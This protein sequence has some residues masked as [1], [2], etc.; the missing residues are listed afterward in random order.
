MISKLIL[1]LRLTITGCFRNSVR[2]FLTITGMCIGMIC[3]ILGN[4]AMS[5][6]V[7][8]AYRKAMSFPEQSF[9]VSGDKEDLNWYADKLS[10]DFKLDRA[11]YRMSDLFTLK[12]RYNYCGKEIYNICVLTGMNTRIENC[13]VPTLESDSAGYGGYFV[14]STT[15]IKGRDF[16]EN[17]IISGNNV[18]I[19]EKSTENAIF[20]NE[21]AIGKTIRLY[22][23]SNSIELTIIGVVNDYFT[24]RER[25]FNFNRNLSSKDSDSISIESSIYVP[26][27]LFDNSTVFDESELKEFLVGKINSEDISRVNNAI[28]SINYDSS[29]SYRPVNCITRG[30]LINEVNKIQ[31]EFNIVKIVFSIFL[32]IISG[33]II[34]TVLLFSIKERIYEIGIRRAVGASS[35]SILTQFITEGTIYSLISLTFATAIST[36]LSNFITYFLRDVSFIDFTM[37][38]PPRIILAAVGISLFE[39]IVFSFIPAFIASHVSPTEAIRWD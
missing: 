22:S 24:T 18:C 20:R 4:S 7:A 9:L 31:E 23:L 12:S 16:T 11:D 25:N 14:G 39:G 6:Y 19:I 32:I 26:D 17:D 33:F 28:E 2:T 37:V 1:Y 5:E 21:S 38:I 10:V 36:F 30:T 34:L 13:P 29:R 35:F 27:K 15:L 8:N 3:F